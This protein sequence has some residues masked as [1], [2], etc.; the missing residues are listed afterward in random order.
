MD[1]FDFLLQHGND[2][3]AP[4]PPLTEPEFEAG[5]FNMCYPFP[6]MPENDHFSAK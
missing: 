1:Y 3:A 4:P 2:S 6:F 5:D